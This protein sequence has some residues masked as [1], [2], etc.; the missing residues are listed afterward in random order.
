MG[1]A[2]GNYDEDSS[3]F[4]AGAI[5]RISEFQDSESVFLHLRSSGWVFVQV[6]LVV[7]SIVALYLLW[8]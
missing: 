8:L 4:V 1:V 2:R 7:S 5:T 6:F 3:F